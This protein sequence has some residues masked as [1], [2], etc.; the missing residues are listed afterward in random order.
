MHVSSV[1]GNTDDA[2]SFTDVVNVDDDIDVYM[3]I[4]E[5]DENGELY[6]GNK[7]LHPR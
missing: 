3:A 7:S 5:D 6:T 1:S 2:L 4:D